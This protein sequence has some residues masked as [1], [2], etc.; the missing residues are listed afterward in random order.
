MPDNK[1][2]SDPELFDEWPERYEDWFRTPIGSLVRQVESKLISELVSP[3][4]GEELLDAGC[5]TGVFTTDFLAAGPSVVG[6]DIS[7]PMLKL[8]VKKAAGAPFSVVQADM[9]NLPFSDECFDKAVSITAL[10]FIAEAKTAIDELFRVTRPGGYVIVATLNSLSP[11]AARRKAKT[12]RG[13]KHILENAYYRNADDLLA[14]SPYPGITRNVV[15]FS[16]DDDV[17]KAREIERRGSERQL[18]TGAFVA[19]RWQ[20][21][22]RDRVSEK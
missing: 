7:R 16:K 8:A 11:W 20:K 5:G 15:H 12:K 1:M 22:G 2:N 19:V 13:Q 6:L 4:P 3:L 14:L 17:D 10:E 9:Q 18:E 21:T